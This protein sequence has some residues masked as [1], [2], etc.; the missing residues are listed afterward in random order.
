MAGWFGVAPYTGAWIEIHM[1]SMLLQCLTSLPTRERGL[2]STI[3][4]GKTTAD[5]VAPYTGAWI[6]ISLMAVSL[7]LYN[8]APYT[9]AWIEI[10]RLSMSWIPG[11]S[12]SLHGSVD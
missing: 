8:V 1:M 4:K 2:K 6:E 3:V 12:R 9:G 7:W 5:T 11:K 10:C